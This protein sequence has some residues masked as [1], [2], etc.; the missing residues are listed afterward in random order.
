MLYHQMPKTTFPWKVGNKNV[1]ITS[2]QYF[3]SKRTHHYERRDRVR[4][5]FENCLSHWNEELLVYPIALQ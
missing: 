5:E 3:E 4:K 2:S 1:N